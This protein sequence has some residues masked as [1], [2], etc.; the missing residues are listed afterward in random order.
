MLSI[1]TPMGNGPTWLL[2][3][4]PSAEGSAWE[5]EVPLRLRVS[6]GRA[7]EG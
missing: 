7:W 1:P 6:L 2:A 4:I 5:E 3:P